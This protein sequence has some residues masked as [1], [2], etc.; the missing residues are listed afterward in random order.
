M[1]DQVG[2]GDL[3]DDDGEVGE[4]EVGEGDQVG[5]DEGMGMMRAW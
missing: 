4:G 3:S 2:D 1:G 5:D